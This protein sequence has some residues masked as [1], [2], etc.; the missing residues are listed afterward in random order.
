MLNK[1]L[2]HSVFCK[3]IM[4]GELVNRFGELNILRHVNKQN[5]AANIPG[6]KSF[7]FPGGW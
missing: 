5:L 1:K 4:K 7:Y 2:Q 6:Q 3:T